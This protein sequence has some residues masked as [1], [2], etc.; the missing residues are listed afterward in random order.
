[1]SA[2]AFFDTTMAL[3]RRIRDATGLEVHI[4]SPLRRE[5]GIR[6]NCS[7]NVSTLASSN[8]ASFEWPPERTSAAKVFSTKQCAADR[9]LSSGLAGRSPPPL[10]ACS[11][12]PL[13]LAGQSENFGCGAGRGQ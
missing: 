9:K 13:P 8:A 2:T 10:L 3:A 11:T 7:T 12:T 6:R 1:V 4:G 5:M